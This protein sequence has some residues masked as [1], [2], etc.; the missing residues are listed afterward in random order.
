MSI[1]MVQEFA[2]KFDLPA[3]DQPKFAC[4]SD[5]KFRIDRLYEEVRES[6]AACALDDFVGFFDALLDLAYVTYGT[7][8]R[9]GITPEQWERGF[10]A[11]HRANMSKIKV[12]DVDDSRFK[13][14]N[15]IIKPKGWTG[16]EQELHK[17]IYG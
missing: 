8:L 10:A 13:N 17:I 1:L 6:Y 11:V 7:A 16:P 3:E 9:V 2:K 12:T 15:D 14:V 4:D 5:I